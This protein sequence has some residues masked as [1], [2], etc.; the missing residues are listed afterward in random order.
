MGR[1][2][3]FKTIEPSEPPVFTK[4]ALQVLWAAFGPQSQM[5]LTVPAGQMDAFNAAVQNIR[6]VVGAQMRA[7]G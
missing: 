7:K 5:P 1:V 2:K 4:D 3:E 6:A